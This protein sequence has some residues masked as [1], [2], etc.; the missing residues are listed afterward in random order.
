MEIEYELAGNC[1]SDCK[2][3][4]DQDFN[5]NRISFEAYEVLPTHTFQIK[6]KE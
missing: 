5:Y 6:G 1:Q 2:K 4:L 3:M